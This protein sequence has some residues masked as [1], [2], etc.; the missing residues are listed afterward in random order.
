V[1]L[2]YEL[3]IVDSVPHDANDRAVEA[4]RTELRWHR[5]ARRVG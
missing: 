5:V 3:Q 4:I 1:G 2:A